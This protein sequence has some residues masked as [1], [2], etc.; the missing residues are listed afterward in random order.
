RALLR[1]P[2][3]LILDDSTSAVDTETEL[4]IRQNL[5]KMEGTTVVIITQRIHTMQ[6]AD[7]VLILEDGRIEAYGTPQEL[8]ESSEMYREIYNSQQIVL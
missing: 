4:R 5:S 8:L 6:S 1:K 2:Q 3:I 7:R